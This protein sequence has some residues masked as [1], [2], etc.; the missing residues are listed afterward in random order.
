MDPN[1][2]DIEGQKTDNLRLRMTW[3][4]TD[5]QTIDA[6][7]AVVDDYRWYET[8]SSANYY[9]FKDDISRLQFSVPF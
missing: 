1:C 4:A 3:A 6:T 8:A 9:T 5:N 2:S 7:V